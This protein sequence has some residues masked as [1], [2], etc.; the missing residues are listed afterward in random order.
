MEMARSLLGLD[1]ST[2]K[3]EAIVTRTL[4]TIAELLPR[5]IQEWG[6]LVSDHV[7]HLVAMNIHGFSGRN[8]ASVSWIMLRFGEYCC[9]VPAQYGFSSFSKSQISTRS[10]FLRLILCP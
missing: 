3:E 10:Y 4:V 2:R 5:P 8:Y 9:P 6:G 1:F 7:S